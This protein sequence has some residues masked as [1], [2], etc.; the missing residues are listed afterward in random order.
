[1]VEKLFEEFVNL[2]MEKYFCGLL[3]KKKVILLLH[4]WIYALVSNDKI[5]NKKF[6]N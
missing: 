5:F 2:V 3:H 1:M 6:I 4:L